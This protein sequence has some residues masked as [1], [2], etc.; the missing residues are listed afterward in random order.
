MWLNR[1]G[2]EWKTHRAHYI[3]NTIW[4]IPQ[5]ALQQTIRLQ[6]SKSAHQRKYKALRAGNVQLNQLGMPK[7]EKMYIINRSRKC[8]KCDT[9]HKLWLCPAYNDECSACGSK[10]HWVRCCRKTTHSKEAR[11]Q[12]RHYRSKSHNYRYLGQRRVEHKRPR[13]I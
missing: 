4:D 12:R 1:Q 2:I 11:R 5:W 7:A 8:R 13:G 3:F 10:E 6:H 9:N